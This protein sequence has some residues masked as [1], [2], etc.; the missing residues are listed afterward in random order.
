MKD[1]L[2]QLIRDEAFLTVTGLLLMMWFASTCTVVTG[3]TLSKRRGFY[4]A[5][6]SEMKDVWEPAMIVTVVWVPIIGWRAWKLLTQPDVESP[7]KSQ[8]RG[9]KPPLPR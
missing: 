6:A 7:P 1:F 8:H 3:Y 9:P 2:K 4:R 5:S